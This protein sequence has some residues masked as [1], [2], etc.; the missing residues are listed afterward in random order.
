MRRSKTEAISDVISR[1]I[2]DMKI[3]RK[4]KEVAITGSWERIAGRAIASRTTKIY[5]RRGTL[6]IHLSSS[7]VRSE[8]MMM[9]EALRERLNSD[10]GEEVVKSIVVR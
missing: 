6:Y 4:L 10:A 8:I 1:Y 3:E 9:R 2:R 7:V 5:I